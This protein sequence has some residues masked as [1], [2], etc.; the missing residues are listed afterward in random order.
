MMRRHH[1]GRVFSISSCSIILL[2]VHVL[3][4]R[5]RSRYERHQSIQLASPSSL[6]TPSVKISVVDRYNLQ[7][8]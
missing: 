3:G 1:S 4:T 6:E 5:Y 7:S 8:L 2:V